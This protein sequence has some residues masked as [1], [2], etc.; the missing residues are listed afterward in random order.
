[1][2]ISFL[3]YF[4]IL[5][6]L[7]ST[8]GVQISESPLAH[9]NQVQVYYFYDS[10]LPNTVSN[11][12]GYLT[13]DLLHKQYQQQIDNKYIIYHKIDIAT[14]KGES[15]ASHCDISMTGLIIGRMS[16]A[17]NLTQSA[18]ALV[19][20]DPEGFQQNLAFN[21]DKLLPKKAKEIHSANEAEKNRQ[22][23]Q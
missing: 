23:K 21:I 9:I 22:K 15:I 19:T 11:R 3:Y 5:M 10:R 7:S 8:K 16:K 1:M 2:S 12:L 13:E 20:Y 14:P 6:S 4:L 18:Y 17:V